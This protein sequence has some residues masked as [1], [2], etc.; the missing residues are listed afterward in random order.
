[1]KAVIGKLGCVLLGASEEQMRECEEYCTVT[2]P[3]RDL[4]GVRNAP[5]ASSAVALCMPRIEKLARRVPI[6]PAA[7]RG[8]QSE[9]ALYMPRM[10]YW[11][12]ANRE[13]LRL[14]IDLPSGA[15]VVHNYQGDL[16]ESKRALVAEVVS[17]LRKFGG[18]TL[19]LDTGLGK[20]KICT[21]V[22]AELGVQALYVVKNRTL[23]EQL[24]AD[25]VR[26]LGAAEPSGKPA[27]G[28][29]M[30]HGVT[31]V[32]I[33]SLAKHPE[34]YFGPHIGLVVYDECREFCSD[35]FSKAFAACPARYLLALGADPE[36]E[37]GLTRRLLLGVGPVYAP[38][39]SRKRFQLS[40]AAVHYESKDRS[41]VF[42]ATGGPSLSLT[43][44]GMLDDR[45]RTD[46]VVCLVAHALARPEAC[47]LAM[48]SRVDL[49]VHYR[50][51]CARAASF[52]LKD[53]AHLSLERLSLDQMFDLLDFATDP[54]L[55]AM[56]DGALVTGETPADVRAA[57][58]SAGQ[59]LIFGTY[60]VLGVGVNLSRMT[61]VLLLTTRKSRIKQYVG[62]VVRQD[63]DPA[64]PRFVYDLV[65]TRYWFA[66]HHEVRAEEYAERGAVV[67]HS[68]ANFVARDWRSPEWRSSLF[69]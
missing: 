8:R 16:W 10:G 65:D 23:F 56:R 39:L 2:R 48:A 4:P 15:P 26:D 63:S 64:I 18:L 62:R 59:R 57:A 12:L 19:Q 35:V 14:G 44:A 13:D 67:T 41:V 58:F 7:S 25:A 69:G 54:A 28:E 20:S 29:P 34:R 17:R 53:R 22:T 51:A 55:E 9:V 40:V 37:D 36:R 1:M 3:P 24:R 47:L 45:E 31:I 49:A 30:P 27:K 61:D 11:P 5:P 60:D 50:D 42:N 33:N 6:P 66:K 52:T 32:I 38:E 46:L 68:Q 43:L 21:A